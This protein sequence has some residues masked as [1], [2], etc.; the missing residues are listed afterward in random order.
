MIKNDRYRNENGND[1]F[2]NGNNNENLGNGNA[3]ENF[4]NG[5]ADENLNESDFFKQAQLRNQ[6][7]NNPR[8]VTRSFDYD[9]SFKQRKID[10]NEAKANRLSLDLKWEKQK[11]QKLQER[12]DNSVP[13]YEY[14][15]VVRL[16]EKG[17]EK[18]KTLEEKPAEDV[19]SKS[20]HEKALENLEAGYAKQRIE[21]EKAHM[22]KIKGLQDKLK[23][24]N[25]T[26]RNKNE[27]DHFKICSDR[28][29]KAQASFFT[30]TR[31]IYQEELI[32]TGIVTCEDYKATRIVGKDSIDVERNK[33]VTFDSLREVVNGNEGK[34]LKL[35][36]S[37]GKDLAE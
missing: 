36:D 5:N 35:V 4:R 9:R 37:M 20:E 24:A 27:K 11:S 7:S 31:R 1:N 10:N 13:T 28:I 26:Q 21:L 32:N 25:D 33:R 6:S 17:L 3:N 18:I 15:R 19:I 34:K 14:D 16:Y 23:K 12:I 29:L 8:Q 22:G 2:R 30:V